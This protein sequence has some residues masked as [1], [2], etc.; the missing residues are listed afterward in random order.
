MIFY[1]QDGHQLGK[2]VDVSVGH[3]VPV[4]IPL[5]GVVH[6]RVVCS[7]RDVKTSSEAGVYGAMGDAM[8]VSG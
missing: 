1:N 4:T 7:G 5:T 8:I 3:P 6:M 2:P